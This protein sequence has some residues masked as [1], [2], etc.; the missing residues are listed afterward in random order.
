MAENGAKE[1]GGNDDP[2]KF[3]FGE[4]F[5]KAGR[6]SD[7][8]EGTF[9]E[10]PEHDA[11][12]ALGGTGTATPGNASNSGSDGNQS[13]A[14]DARKPRSDKG[15]PRGSRTAKAAESVYLGGFED[16][17]FALHLGLAA[18]AKCEEL[19]L[20]EDEAKKVTIA[21]DRLAKHYHVEPTETQKI[22]MQF[23]GAMTAVYGPRVIAIKKR[24]ER[25]ANLKGEKVVP[26]RG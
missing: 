16:A 1:T 13:T 6:S 20:D 10:I 15:R 22:W 26:I 3:D 25:E 11:A 17:I 12:E 4:S 18:V 24:L 23:A 14:S 9:N 5:F 21:L 2:Y 19:E 7:A 8:I